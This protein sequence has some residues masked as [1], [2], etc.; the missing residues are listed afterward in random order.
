MDKG[1][2]LLDTFS[3]LLNSSLTAVYPDISSDQIKNLIEFGVGHSDFLRKVRHE[4]DKQY[5]SAKVSG[6]I[7]FRHYHIISLLI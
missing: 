2:D 6:L 5:H 4:G 3:K 7:I 1:E